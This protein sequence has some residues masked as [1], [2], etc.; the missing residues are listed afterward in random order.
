MA[1]VRGTGSR[2]ISIREGST[3]E[4]ERAHRHTKACPHAHART[5]TGEEKQRVR[6][7]PNAATPSWDLPNWR[8]IF[9]RGRNWC[10]M[11]LKVHREPLHP[12][13]PLCKWILNTAEIWQHQSLAHQSPWE[14][15]PPR[16]KAPNSRDQ[17][18]DDNTEYR[19][20]G[21]RPNAV[22]SESAA[23]LPVIL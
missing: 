3:S 6:S 7:I 5:T 17:N 8:I 16:Q 4:C 2:P 13:N 14:A 22:G 21:R 1:E 18:H 12:P 9:P 19:I 23:S 10:G 15:L 11:T 20:W